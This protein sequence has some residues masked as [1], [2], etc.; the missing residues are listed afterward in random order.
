M[1]TSE[2][3]YRG[4][5]GNDIPGRP[6]TKLDQ[7][8][9]QK[10]A[11]DTSEGATSVSTDGAGVM[12]GRTPKGTSKSTS[13]Q[14]TSVA[15]ES[16]SRAVFKV[17]TTHS[18]VHTLSHTIFT[19]QLTQLTLLTL[20]LQFVIFWYLPRFISGP[21]FLLY[22][23][24]WRTAYD[25]GLGYVLRKQSEKK[26]IV[27]KLQ[28]FGWLNKNEDKGAVDQGWSAWWKKEL[29]AKLGN[30]GYRW[31]DVPEEFN[32]WLI[33]RQLVDIIL[34]KWVRTLLEISFIHAHPLYRAA[35]SYPTA[36]SPS[37]TSTF[38]RTNPSSPTPFAGSSAGR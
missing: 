29:E 11:K 23:A 34:L 5:S 17:P 7:E 18:F 20:G 15:A 26:W 19:S 16:E 32:S 3:R 8:Q 12:Y 31:D 36:S 1:E 14:M 33:F 21:F 38:P 9:E 27:R 24:F 2:L 13:P 25:A 22:F 10:H 37:P 28:S 35:T 4:P 30:E 6:T